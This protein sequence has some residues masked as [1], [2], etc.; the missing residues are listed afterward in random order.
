VRIDM[1]R[2]LVQLGP[3]VRLDFGGIAKGYAVDRAC[4]LLAEAGPCLVNAGGD[5]AVRGTLGGGPWPVGI[6]VPNG[7]MTLNLGGG[8]MATTGRDLRRWS[9]NGQERHHVIDPATGRPSESDILRIT[10][11]AHSAV[12]AEVLA[13]SLFLAGEQ[14]AVREAGELCVPCVLV[15]ADDRLVLAGGLE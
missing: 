7:S 11:V 8:A 1:E 15:S 13:K 2:S 3:G 4:E 14:R 6:D 9:R 12:D 10:V 5:L